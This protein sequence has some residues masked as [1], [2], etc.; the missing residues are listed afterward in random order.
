MDM[1]RGQGQ[2]RR[3]AQ[4]TWRLETPFSVSGSQRHA[5]ARSPRAGLRGL[6]CLCISQVEGAQLSS[7]SPSPTYSSPLPGLHFP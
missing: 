4:P 6:S 3:P 5:G 2:A 7:V 1:E